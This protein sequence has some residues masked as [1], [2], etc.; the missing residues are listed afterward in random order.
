MGSSVLDNLWVI[1]SS[2]LVFLMQPGFMCLESGLTRSKNSINVAIKNLADFVFSV[3]GF[4]FLGFGLMFGLSHAGI[5]GTS[6]FL[7]DFGDNFHQSSFFLFQTMF[8]G[9][10]T[11]IFSGAVAERMRFSSYLIVV[12]LLSVLIY[13]VFGHWAWNGI[14][15][16]NP[17]GWLGAAGFVDFA[18]STVV[19]SVGG[20]VA[21]ATLMVIGPRN[22][23]FTPEGKTVEVHGSDLPLSVLGTLLLWIGWIGFNGGSTL[24][25]N[26][27]VPGIIVN[28]VMAGVSG[29]VV[30]LFAGL[31]FNRIAKVTYLINGCLGGLVAITACCHCVTIPQA[32]LIGA[33]AG[34]ICLFAE[35]LLLYYGI[36]DA[37]GAVPVHLG[38]GV[39]GTLAVAFFGKSEVLNTGLD[40]YSQLLVQA[41]GVAGAFVVAFVIP[42]F[43]IRR[44]DRIMPLR[45]SAESEEMGLNISEHGAK[46]ETADFF[47]IMQLQ[48]E[49]GD[50]SLRVPVDPFTDTGV[51]AGR[52]NKVMAA[53]QNAIASTE[54]IVSVA[55]DAIVTFG[56][57]LSVISMNPS[58]CA[59]FGYDG[60]PAGKGLLAGLRMEHLIDMDEWWS[61]SRIKNNSSRLAGSAKGADLPG[62][63]S[64][65][66][67]A[68]RMK[69]LLS[70]C[71]MEITGKK[72]C[73]TTFPMDA[74]VTK[75]DVVKD[76][77]Y[78]GIFRDI[79]VTREK[80]AELAKQKAYFKQLFDGSP[81]AVI[82]TDLHGNIT[83][84]NTGFETLFGYSAHEVCHRMNSC[85]I[86]PDERRV[87]MTSIRQTILSGSIVHKETWRK[88]KHGRSIP[89]S[90]LGFSIVINGM[91]EGLFYV[92]QDITQRKELEDQLY[93]KAFYDSLT[94]VPNRIL[95][96][97]RLGQAVS[98]QKRKENFH[99][100][101]FMIDLDRFKWVN[102]TLGHPA[103]DILLEKTA[104][105]FLTCVR[106]M[107]T[108]ARIGGDEFAVLLEDIASERET[109]G[110]AKR[111]G[112]QAA[113]VFKINGNDVSIS[114][115][116]GIVVK[117]AMYQKP[118]DILRD[119]DIAM[120]RAKA[121]GKSRCKV[122][123]R[124]LHRI[125]HDAL[126]L[127]KDL[128]GVVERNELV[129]Y[130][131]PQVCSK[132]GSIRGFEALL[133]WN[134]PRRGLVLPMDFICLAEETGLII[135]IGNWV[136]EQACRQLKEWHTNLP[137]ARQLS[138]SVNLSS[139]QFMRH[140]L[141]QT[142]K[143]AL[144]AVDLS[145]RFLV[146]EL[147]ESAVMEKP[148][149]VIGQLNRLKDTGIRIAID[150]FGTGYSSLAYLRLFPL[151]YL[152]M[153][154]RFVDEI[155]RD[156][157]NMT[158]AKAIITLAHNLNLE[159]IAEG[160][161]RMDQLET[162]QGLNCNYIQGYFY[163]RPI[164]QARAAL[165]IENG[166]VS[167]DERT[168]AE[169]DVNT[170]PP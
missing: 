65:G 163:S 53:L 126:Q 5:I 99:F 152:K 36:D 60:P 161:E 2:V 148:E 62:K 19:H 114:S 55:K 16:G 1:V 18:G 169:Q 105:R 77:F 100:A 6:G 97:E 143:N 78:V 136:I 151:D 87:E 159:V 41:E 162:L 165:L 124:K 83:R 145:P 44:I 108:V 8:C 32:I 49:T 57:D 39:W 75:A 122:F 139:R 81:Q 7:A 89:V 160:I 90:L 42:L 156:H 69:E 120:Y 68:Y 76:P 52:Y 61:R 31:S 35:E 3:M 111:M 94:G 70:G 170:T 96:M 116:I 30:S 110:I 4:W 14:D 46:T 66:P 127:E 63:G 146:A 58:G 115:S 154:K 9:T 82:S 88:H 45:V 33:V 15:S 95:F 37:V 54:A 138:M 147:T 24:A 10:A 157:E 20:W 50:L 128:R 29:S 21:L 11:T 168:P 123:S 141:E 64:H 119:A 137:A 25:F 131:Q 17:A 56:D 79:T 155:N 27:S 150:D 112:D 72:E 104:R 166:F 38:C 142:I 84:V 22:G 51:I 101:V 103:G 117:T 113:R 158:I 34:V 144:D 74:V 118:E 132:S 28:T 23:R 91:M 93:R 102:D 12:M 133:R 59:M 71:R 86:V 106:S 130:Y 134:H 125:T 149:S 153:D 47:R 129:L 26:G 135:P 67:M 85:I 92:Y 140:D 121:K 73:G 164:D 43:I 13:P 167:R 48:E 107:D 80:E 109:L 40:V 98:R